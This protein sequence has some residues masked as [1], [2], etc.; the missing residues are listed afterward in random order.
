MRQAMMSTIFKSFSKFKS[1]KAKGDG[2]LGPLTTL[3]PKET[4]LLTTLDNEAKKR[5]NRTVLDNLL[6]V[7]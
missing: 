1:K 7:F 2:S 5:I 6:F 4:V 3:E